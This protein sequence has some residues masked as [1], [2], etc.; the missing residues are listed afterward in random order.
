MV[1][2]LKG[3]IKS[4]HILVAV[5]LFLALFFRF[6]KLTDWFSFGMDQEYEA[7]LVR[8]IITGKHFP[9][10]GVNAGGT[11]IYLGPIF[12]YLASLPYLIFRGN[13]LGWAVTASF[14]GVITTWLIYHIVAKLFNQKAALFSSFFYA[15]SFLASFYDRSFWNPSLVP[16]LSLLIIYFL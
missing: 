15:V 6:Y 2:R 8:N 12:I 13:P 14:L 11:G 3:T 5:I 10:I 1:K 9:L 7:F 16:L 4:Q